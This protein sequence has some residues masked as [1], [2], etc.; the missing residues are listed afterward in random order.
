MKINTNMIILEIKGLSG[1]QIQE[2]LNSFLLN[3]KE[4]YF[5][6]DLTATSVTNEGAEKIK[7]VINEW[8]LN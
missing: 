8:K 5:G 7:Q 2:E 3:L 4:N 6:L 1:D